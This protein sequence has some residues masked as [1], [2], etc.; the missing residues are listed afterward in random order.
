[1]PEVTN[2]K[3]GIKYTV[4]KTELDNIKKS[5]IADFYTYDDDVKTPP[6]AKKIEEKT[7]GGKR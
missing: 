7:T 4:N 5:D 6:E 2:K 3:T 1:M